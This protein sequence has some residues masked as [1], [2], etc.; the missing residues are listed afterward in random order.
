MERGL[1]LCLFAFSIF[2]ACAGE[3]E[4]YADQELFDA[5]QIV[6]SDV[7]PIFETE[8]VFCHADPPQVGAPQPLITYQ[9]VVPWLTRIQVR[10]IGQ[11][12]MPPGGLKSER[13]LKLLQAWIEQGALETKTRSV[14]GEAAGEEVAGEEVAG[15]EEPMMPTWRGGISQLF[16]IYCNTCHA[17]P[18]TGGAPF[19]LKRY[20]DALPYLERYQVRVINRLDMPPGGIQDQVSLDLLQ[21]WIDAGGP[22]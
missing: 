8:C 6:W 11:H 22:E 13:D 17:D 7:E 15:E 18:P 1:S 20:Q 10:V 4:R 16:E 14:G 19:S 21:R 3:G 12:D 2:L 9:Q 5:N